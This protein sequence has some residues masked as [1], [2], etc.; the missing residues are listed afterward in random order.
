[1]HKNDRLT[2][3]YELFI[4]NKLDIEKFRIL[5]SPCVVKKYTVYTQNING[6]YVNQ[7]VQKKLI[8]EE[9]EVFL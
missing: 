4:N 8:K 2:T 7:D 5:F 3:P 9:Y 6:K 1:M